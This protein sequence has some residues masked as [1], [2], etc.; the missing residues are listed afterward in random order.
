MTLTSSTY[1]PTVR[2]PQAG[3]RRPLGPA[4]RTTDGCPFAPEPHAGLTVR[5][6]RG[7]ADLELFSRR[8]PTTAQ[9][10]K[11]HVQSRSARF[12]DF[13]LTY[14]VH[15]PLRFEA[16]ASDFGH[17][18]RTLR[19]LVVLDGEVTLRHGDSQTT[20]GRRDGALVLGWAPVCYQA[21]APARVVVCDVPA[22]HGVLGGLP[23]GAPFVVARSASALLPALGAFAV[24]LLRQDV[25][26]L[27]PAVR[28]QVTD[29]LDSLVS[30]TVATL[31]VSGD[32]EWSRRAQRLH[33]IRYIA[34]HY[35]DPELSPTTLAEHVGMSKRS[36]QRLFEGERLSV[37]QWIQAK[38]VDQALLRLRDPRYAGTSLE[39]LA[40]LTGFGSALALRRAVQAATGQAPSALRAEAVGVTTI[41]AR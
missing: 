18:V 1:R 9:P 4:A 37:S 12:G 22:D 24:D 15:G 32:A 34:A 8:V 7:A 16:A 27:S 19:L 14:M 25:D 39:E 41:P 29:A 38:R 3:V 36:L 40:V 17:G 33:V 28:A 30:G 13:T 5:E 20:L 10:E 23:E 2:R 35:A 26:A 21:D 6:W 31:A 11:F